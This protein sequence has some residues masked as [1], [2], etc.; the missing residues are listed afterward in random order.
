[1]DLLWIV[2]LIALGLG[3]FM[4]LDTKYKFFSSK[5]EKCRIILFEKVGTE[6]V[7]KKQV[8]APIKYD[9]KLGYYI[10]INKKVAMPVTDPKNFY[11]D[12]KVERCLMVI[13]YGPDDY[14][15]ISRLDQGVWGKLE[16]AE[17]LKLDANGEPIPRLDENGKQLMEDGE[18]CFETEMRQALNYYEEPQ[19]VTQLARE[20]VRFNR[21][22]QKRMDELRKEKESW[23]DKNGNMVIGVGVIVIFMIFTVYQSNGYRKAIE[24]MSGTFAEEMDGAV[25]SI[26]QPHWAENLLET[27]QRKDN[28]QNTPLS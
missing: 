23:W 15:P 16:D 13:K 3:S 14:R 22:F 17:Q 25:K 10:Q 28:E 8:I 26:N 6:K 1:M 21:A 2:V 9:A 11:Y 20:G 5:G 12:N 4:L 24:T 18:I 27:V 7:H 19:G